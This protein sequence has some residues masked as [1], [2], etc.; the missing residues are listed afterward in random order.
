MSW[1]MGE[2]EAGLC[3]VAG[4]DFGGGWN[5]MSHRK[6]SLPVG[7]EGQHIAYVAHQVTGN[8]ADVYYL[9]PWSDGRP[10]KGALTDRLQEEWFNR[11][12][13]HDLRRA[14]SLGETS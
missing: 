3:L 9:G 11:D 1:Q 4:D 10:Y 8:G 5:S 12:P 6:C 7:H 14:S 2:I 13:D